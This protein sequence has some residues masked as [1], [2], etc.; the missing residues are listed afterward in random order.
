MKTLI[1][2][3]ALLILPAAGAHA[4]QDPQQ[5]PADP[6]AKAA[7][8]DEAKPT[9]LKGFVDK[10]G[11]G[12]DDRRKGTAGSGGEGRQTRQRHGRASDTFIDADGDG[13]NDNRCGGMGLQK[14]CGRGR[15][16]CDN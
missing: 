15:R 13:I 5:K 14:R 2:F 16:E 4:Q 3:A 9:P 12:I 1:L 7:K 8:G 11:D 10:N 6:P